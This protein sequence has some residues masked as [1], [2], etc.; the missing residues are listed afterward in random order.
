MSAPSSLA[1]PAAPASARGRDGRAI[2]APARLRLDRT[3]LL[4]L[5]AACGLAAI[6]QR[7]A[8]HCFFFADD[9][10]YLFRMNDAPFSELFLVPNAGHLLMFRNLLW[11]GTWLVFGAEPLGYFVIVLVTHVLNVGLLFLLARRLEVPTGIA[12]V[13]AALWGCLGVN[14]ATLGWY[15]VYGQVVAATLTLVI[16]H[17]ALRCATPLRP[18][19]HA[20]MIGLIL[21]LGTSFGSG[22]AIALI[23]PLAL[24]LLRPALRLRRLPPFIGA[25]AALLLLWVVIQINYAEADVFQIQR[26]VAPDAAAVASASVFDSFR[27]L[28][29]DP[30]AGLMFLD[31][32]G[33]GAFSVFVGPFSSLYFTNIPARIALALLAVGAGLGVRLAS[34]AQRRRLLAFA[35][36]L[37]GVYASVAAGRARIFTSILGGSLPP[38]VER[39]HYLPTLLLVV[40]GA[41]LA[42]AVAEGVS[43]RVRAALFAATLAALA[44]LIAVH[45]VVYDRHEA[46]QAGVARARREI[47]RAA[48]SA[49]GPVATIA[50]RPV[51]V[52]LIVPQ[53][54]FPGL[55]AVFVIYY[56]GD[57]LFGRRIRFSDPD[58]AVLAAARRGRR[59]RTLF[60][61]G[62]APEP[63]PS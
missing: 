49:E 63:N 41:V 9:F 10:L 53:A 8:L 56:P 50:N 15:A 21:A 47:E 7:D 20:L 6:A 48:R 1:A 19:L 62:D 33:H 5:L 32:I 52:Y 36:L 60:A 45:P 43:A 34:T 57:T 25:A 39:Y 51:N 29:V 61:D 30:R 28:Y 4:A 37:A 17:L 40:I 22:L 31:L 2:D 54:T 44:L 14:A 46:L 3:A 38:I 16:L 18:A 12:C 58:P 35:L 13:A 27:T 11:L 24:W 26:I 55:A 42:T 59:T 23:L